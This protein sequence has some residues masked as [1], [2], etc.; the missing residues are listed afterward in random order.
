VWRWREKTIVSMLVAALCVLLGR[1]VEL[2]FIRGPQFARIARRQHLAEE[3]I[4][5]RPG[6][7]CDREGRLLATSVEVASLFLVPEQLDSPW[8]TCE[9][10]GLALGIDAQILMDRVTARPESQFLW[11]KRRLSAAERARVEA[12]ELTPG[13]WGFREEYL[14]VYPQG[15]VAAQVV[16]L[17]DIDGI[18]RGG[19]EEACQVALR[20]RDG[21]RQVRRDARGRVVEAL[22]RL[23]RPL[24]Q[25]GEVQ[26]TLDTVLQLHAEQTLAEVAATWKPKSC[27]AV[28][29]DPR[30]G[31]LL[32]MASWPGYDPNHPAGISAASWKN[33]PLVDMYEPGSTFKPFIVAWA[34][35]QGRLR[36]EDVFDC[37]NGAYKMGRR[38]LHD[39]HRYGSL[40]V[41]DILV[42]SS[43]I[44]MAKIGERL[45]N[46]GLFD[47][48]RG[49][50]FGAVT[51]VALPGELPGKLRPLSEWNGYSTG[52]VPMGQE[53]AVTPLQT[54]VAY[55]ALAN[56]GEWIAPRLIRRINRSDALAS[57]IV[58]R[59]V[60]PE[61]AHWLCTGPL[62]EVVTR[63]TGK[64]ARLDGYRVFGKSGTAQK[65]DPATGRYSNRLHVS[66]FVCGAPADAPRAIVVVSVDEPSTP[67]EHFG[68][69]IA[70]PAAASILKK[71]LER[72]HVP[73]G[74]RVA[75]RAEEAEGGVFE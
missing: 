31:E 60:D 28:V 57:P 6:D 71:T 64:R 21:V 7:I 34:I 14:R 43:N 10:L 49:F 62:V 2:Q 33:R 41:T 61:T 32:V 4:P 69:T 66:S 16:G 54:A 38:V 75:D 29:I 42:K 50:G 59:V 18:G 26:L 68:G 23:D 67:G 17:R 55:A 40:D 48:A 19:V 70:A 1:L 22:D 44:G 65:P 63:G 73:P 36:R 52:S 45:T 20:G 56:K 37:E 72:L 39:H 47:A 9:R 51:G 13:T 3:P 8:T 12:L 24:E 46:A 30:T 74:D 35:E 5:A 53:I 58:A 11:V 15:S 25:G 27:C